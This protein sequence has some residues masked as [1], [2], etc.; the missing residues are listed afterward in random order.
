VTL[1]YTLDDDGTP[2][3]CNDPVFWAGWYQLANRCV[4][5][6]HIG[7]VRVSTVFLGINHNYAGFGLPVLWET[8]VFGGDLDGEGG[9][10]CSREEAIAGHANMVDR[11][12]ASGKE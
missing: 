6:T 3:P 7:A 1:Y 12:R 5:E 2:V 10:Y 4:A 11:V 9:R 8:L